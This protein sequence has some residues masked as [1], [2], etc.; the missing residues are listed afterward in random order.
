MTHAHNRDVA[1]DKWRM[2]RRHQE[3][4]QAQ[5]KL[6][7][8]PLRWLYQAVASAFVRPLVIFPDTLRATEFWGHAASVTAAW[9]FDDMESGVKRIGATVSLWRDPPRTVDEMDSFLSTDVRSRRGAVPCALEHARYY[10]RMRG[11]PRTW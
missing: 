5:S 7:S 11:A 4:L 1:R 2:R 3:L 6:P 10:Y 9:G 8:G